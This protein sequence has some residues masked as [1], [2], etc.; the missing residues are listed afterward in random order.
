MVRVYWAMA[1]ED[2]SS[3]FKSRILAISLLE[4]WTP[5]GGLADAGRPRHYTYWDS[6]GEEELVRRVLSR[7]V[8]LRS[9]EGARLVSVIGFNILR[10]DIPLINS[11]ALG[12]G[13]ASATDLAEL[14]FDSFVIDLVQA[15][16]PS[17]GMRFKSITVEELARQARMHGY[18][19]EVPDRRGIL[20]A[21]RRRDTGYILRQNEALI[22]LVRL[23]DQRPEI[24]SARPRR[25]I[26]GGIVW[27]RG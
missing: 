15:M 20:V 11:R 17:R 14:W 9:V 3:P 23:A 13:V 18:S 19:V 10:L 26:G 4:D 21:W 16:L 5:Y 22:R 8:E 12:Y 25:R 2:Y 1:L 27:P 24:L 7:L 6:S